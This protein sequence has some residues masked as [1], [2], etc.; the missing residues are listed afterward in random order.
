MCAPACSAFDATVIHVH[1]TCS[2]LPTSLLQVSSTVVTVHHVTMISIL[3]FI[4]EQS[5]FRVFPD[6]KE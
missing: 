3:F 6:H 2:K 4:Q 1:D 5:I